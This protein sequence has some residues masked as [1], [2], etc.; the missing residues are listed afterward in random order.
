MGSSITR[1]IYLLSTVFVLVVLVYLDV[2][3]PQAAIVVFLLLLIV[4]TY[5]RREERSL[6]HG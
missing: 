1:V 4:L 2:L 6:V 3:N 5:L